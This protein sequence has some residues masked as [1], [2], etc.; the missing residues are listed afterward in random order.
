MTKTYQILSESLN[1]IVMGIG[2]P[3]AAFATWTLNKHIRAWRVLKAYP[4]PALLKAKLAASPNALVRAA[5][6]E[7]SEDMTMGQYKQWVMT[8]TSPKMGI[9]KAIL[10]YLFSGIALV[11]QG[12]KAGIHAGESSDTILDRAA[13]KGRFAN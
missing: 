6:E 13:E 4:T 11:A 7:L 3:V 10:M 9:G 1:P 5:A 8:K 2:I 12:V